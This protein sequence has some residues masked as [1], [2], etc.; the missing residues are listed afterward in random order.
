MPG[1][2]SA[3]RLAVRDSLAARGGDRGSRDWKEPGAEERRG[4]CVTPGRRV[5]DREHQDIGLQGTAGVWEAAGGGPSVRGAGAGRGAGEVAAE[6]A[7]PG[8]RGGD[9]RQGD[10]LLRATGG[11]AT[12]ASGEAT[13]GDGEV[14]RGAR[15]PG[16]TEEG[17]G[18]GVGEGVA[19]ACHL[20]S[21]CHGTRDGADPGGAVD[22]DRGDTT[23]VPDAGP[24]QGLLRAGDRHAFLLRLGPERERWLGACAGAADARTES[25]PQRTPEEHLQGS[26]HDDRGEAAGRS[27]A[28]AL[29]EA[30]RG[31]HEAEP[32]QAHNR[33]QSGRRRSEDVEGWKGVRAAE[34][35]SDTARRDRFPGALI[36]PSE[37]SDD[38]PEGRRREEVGGEHPPGTWSHPMV[39]SPRKGYAPPQYRMK[40]W[41]KEAQMEG[42]FPPESGEQACLQVAEAAE[43]RADREDRSPSVPPDGPTVERS[44]LRTAR[45]L[46]PQRTS[47]GRRGVD[48]GRQTVPATG[49]VSL[50]ILLHGRCQAESAGRPARNSG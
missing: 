4:G 30:D 11:L 6:G 25:Q 47:P 22:P 45:G 18:G 21:A 13:L 44:P 29:R 1:G 26:G 40:Q 48:A 2:G 39:E 24:V 7:V 19:P 33:T 46:A 5:A 8:T 31:G 34:A 23:P 16:R 50:D 3:E 37:R 42:W 15:R 20:E 32:G 28:R 10:L 9:A 14:A 41:P 49:K 38:Q 35:S 27:L 17:S 43:S 12:E 36:G